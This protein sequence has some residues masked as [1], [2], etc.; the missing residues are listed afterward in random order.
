MRTPLTP[1]QRAAASAREKRRRAAII[2]RRK[3]MWLALPP[4]T[5]RGYGPSVLDPEDFAH[6]RSDVTLGP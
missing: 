3:K 6:P 1:E 5:V 2:E 4:G